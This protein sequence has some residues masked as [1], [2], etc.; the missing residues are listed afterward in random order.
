M[1]AIQ[2]YVNLQHFITFICIH[3]GGYPAGGG[4]YP[5]G[6]GGYP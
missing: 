2:I 3:R 5:A 4:G 1:Y 6:G